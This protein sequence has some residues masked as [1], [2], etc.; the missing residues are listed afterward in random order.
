[1]KIDR[2]YYNGVIRTMVSE[3]DTVE[4]L[5]VH[6]GTIVAAG[7]SK[8]MRAI[9]A[10]E[11]V[12]LQ[13]RSVLPGFADTHMHLFHDCMG[14]ITPNLS[15][16]H[17]IPEILSLLEQ[18]KESIKPGQWLTAEN[19]HLEFLKEGRFPN[20]DELDSVS[21]EIPICIGSFCHHVHV[22]NSAALALA[23]ID[24]SF[25]P[26]VADHVGRFDDGRPDG[27]VREVVYPEHVDPVIPRMSL[28]ECVDAVH[29]HLQYCSSLGLTQLEVNQE[30]GPF[31]AR[32]YTE[33]RRQKGLP[34]H[35]TLNWYP[36][37][38]NVRGLV[39]GFGDDDLKLGAIKMLTDGGIGS[40]GA[41]MLEDYENPV[42]TRGEC[43]Y[44]QEELDELVKTAYDAGHD[45]SIHAI[46]D[47]ANDMVLTAFERA[48]DPAVGDARRFYF[49]HATLVSNTF[50][51]RAA[52]IPCVIAIQPVWLENFVNFGELRLGKE[53]ANRLFQIK[54]MMDAGLIV[55]GGT[56][57]P[58]CTVNPFYG[59]ECAVIRQ[60][61]GRD[62]VTL[63]A[64]QAISVYQAVEMVTKNAAYW[65]SEEHRKGTLEVG[66]L[67][68]FIVLDRDIFAIDPK[69]IHETQVQLTVL[70]GDV[71]FERA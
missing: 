71:V 40:A 62:D 36:E 63:G 47:A 6:N 68:D 28:Q 56:D 19:M 5:A 39:T 22:L 50:I 31:G 49:V 7:T 52:K 42:G 57:A 8:E 20:C 2:V 41:L 38:P 58:V 10:C 3:G 61:V 21:S 53:R 15:G 32:L 48:Y 17:S 43:N 37:Y 14:R 30:D 44:T 45:V 27:V 33:M 60:A 51:E 35:L 69:L 18:R 34:C 65:C 54:D 12:D 70:N 13:G 9:D 29:E 67:A 24:A 23:G 25:Q 46:G 66:K 64:D 11:Y 1:M 16:C 26:M 59:V 4:A 55:A